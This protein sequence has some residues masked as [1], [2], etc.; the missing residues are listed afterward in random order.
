MLALYERVDAMRR[1]AVGEDLQIDVVGNGF[2]CH[3]LYV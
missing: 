1:A 3:S 2:A